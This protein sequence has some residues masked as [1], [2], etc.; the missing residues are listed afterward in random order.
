MTTSGEPVEIRRSRRRKRT[1]SAYR[2]D[3][4]TIV[5]VPARLTRAE[6]EMW[7]ARMLERL[8]RKEARPS[9]AE[10][11]TRARALSAR[12]LAGR[13]EPLSVTWSERQRQR[14]G[15]CTTAE[16]T[17]RLS[18]RLRG[19]PPFVVDYVLLHELAHLVEPHHGP[20]FWALLDAYPHTERAKGFLEGAAWQEGAPASGDGDPDVD[21]IDDAA[22]S[23]QPERGLDE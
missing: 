17:I 1:V 16:R 18:A 20:A 23:A 13:A 14:W 10:L 12:W 21:D 8:D 19:M 7:V 3:G 6:E 15:S 2:R 5:L 9:D 11:L 22:P 4:R